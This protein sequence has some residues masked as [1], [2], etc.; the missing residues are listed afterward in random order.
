L[1]LLSLKETVDHEEKFWYIN[2]EYSYI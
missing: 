2:I 1:D